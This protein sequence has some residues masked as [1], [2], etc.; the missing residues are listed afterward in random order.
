M[1]RKRLTRFFG[2]KWARYRLVLMGIRKAGWSRPNRDSGSD[3]GGR[4]SGFRFGDER[5]KVR[6]ASH[7]V[8]VSDEVKVFHL[9]DEIVLVKVS[10]ARKRKQVLE[11]LLDLLFFESFSRFF[12]RDDFDRFFLEGFIIII[13]N[14]FFF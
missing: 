2:Y 9:P 5:I 12:F 1:T 6:R 4:C 14:R 10:I 7:D 3:C 13:I 8:G 11:R